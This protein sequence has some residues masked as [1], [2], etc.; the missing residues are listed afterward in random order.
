M[1]HPGYLTDIQVTT[2][3]FH[4]NHL[5]C[6]Q[7]KDPVCCYIECQVNQNAIDCNKADSGI[8]KIILRIRQ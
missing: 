7:F 6:Y 8:G 4:Q 2:N 5:E 3:C 1:E